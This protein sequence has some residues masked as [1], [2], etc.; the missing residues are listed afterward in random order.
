MLDNPAFHDEDDVFGDV[1][2]QV[3][4]ALQ[5][6]DDDEKMVQPRY[7]ARPWNFILPY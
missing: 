3:G 1:G 6:P 5:I 2:G 7:P 4:D